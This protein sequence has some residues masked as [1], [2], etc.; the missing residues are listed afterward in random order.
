MFNL[1]KEA[2]CLSINSE[3]AWSMK[4]LMPQEDPGRCQSI[5]VLLTKTSLD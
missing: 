5:L 3:V 2:L 1:V 4:S